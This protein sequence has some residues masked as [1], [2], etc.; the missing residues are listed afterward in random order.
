MLSMAE[1][2][3]LSEI[4]GER[5]Y[6]HVAHM[7]TLMER[8]SGSEAEYQS[9]LKAKAILE[10]F[11]DICELEGYS[12]ATN[13][14][15]RG[16]LEIIEPFSRSIACEVNGLSGSDKGTGRLL[17]VGSGTRYDYERLGGEVQGA[18][19]LI[20]AS[21][22]RIGVWWQPLAREA[23]LRGA[24]CLIYH[25][26]GW[27]DNVLC[28]HGINFD[29]PVL[30]IS[31]SSAAD[32]RK[33]LAKHDKV[34]VQFEAN[35][36]S[37]P[38]TG[39]SVVGTINGGQYPQ[40]V[41]YL[42]G[43]H[44]GYFHGANDNL[45]SCAC[46][47]EVARLLSQHRPQR[48]FKFVLFGGEESGRPVAQN[49]VAGLHGSFCYS[50]AH[51]SELVGNTGQLTVCA[52]NGEYLGHTPR[53]RVTCSPELI[54]LVKEVAAQLGDHIEVVGAPDRTWTD[55]DHLCLHTLGIPTIYLH[56]RVADKGSGWL[57]R[58]SRV[59][60]TVEDNIDI[61]SPR[62]LES[63]A[64]LMALLA[65][66]LDAADFPPY[67]MESVIAEVERGS[68]RLPGRGELIDIIREKTLLISKIPDREKKMRRLLNLL[69]ITNTQVYTYILRDF[70][71][72]YRLLSD[73]VVKLREAYHIADME[74]D[75]ERARAVLVSIAWGSLMDSFS[76]EVLEQ[77]KAVKASP[78]VLS[79][80]SSYYFELRDLLDQIDSGAAIGEVLTSIEVKI[81][82]VMETATRWQQEFIG[83]VRGV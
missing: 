80:I 77:I 69:A 34:T 27:E 56:D 36:F 59:Y 63:N 49:I 6:G 48:T 72:K 60:H 39:H 25:P 32:L 16:R 18:A 61:I 55:S 81:G 10:P 54:P 29:F 28:V 50:E 58:A 37:R 52:I 45:S 70:L 42:S 12:A 43:H 38:S 21:R 31:N 24:S 8:T 74:G 82:E 83:A 62:A 5:A 75:L 51:C 33:L 44:D 3:I 71:H 65:L 1:E 53:S 78:S 20:A 11:V 14:R 19:V 26:G 15:G 41:I 73:T 79:R 13:I 35:H 17:Y 66:R 57:S 46:V 47:I 64:R 76:T 68:D 67:S 2:Q 40:E 22:Q 7:Q 9:A 4:S 23:A 30:T